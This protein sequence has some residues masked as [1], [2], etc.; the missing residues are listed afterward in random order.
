M[1]EDFKFKSVSQQN[2]ILLKIDECN[3]FFGEMTYKNELNEELPLFPTTSNLAEI[4]KNPKTQK[5]RNGFGVQIVLDQTGEIQSKMEGSWQNNHLHG[6]SKVLYKSGAEFDGKI[7]NDRRE[8]FGRL[9]LPDGKTY[10]GFWHNDCMEGPGVFQ[11]GEQQL[12]GNFVNN[13]YVTNENCLLNPFETCDPNKVNS[14]ELQSAQQIRDCNI[15]LKNYRILETGFPVE[16]VAFANQ[17][18]KNDRFCFVVFEINSDWNFAK[19][20]REFGDGNRVI[21]DC[22][23][24][25][26]LSIRD[27]AALEEYMTTLNRDIRNVLSQGGLIV[28]S[29]DEPSRAEFRKEL[30]VDFKAL[31]SV[32]PLVNCLFNIKNLKMTAKFSHFLKM[33]NVGE[34][35]GILVYSKWKMPQE[36][37]QIQIKQQIVNRF[38]YVCNVSWGDVILFK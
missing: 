32:N 29:V 24:I 13:L 28:I 33:D 18:F 19:V 23:K 15:H 25:E 1:I 17:S 12:Q 16:T 38:Q 27:K 10:Q 9:K 5:D 22:Q 34:N 4:L 20:L 21:I 31:A 3:Y 7:L 35:C 8:G 30:D 36:L 11:N 14:K 2:F 6:V 37:S 26:Y